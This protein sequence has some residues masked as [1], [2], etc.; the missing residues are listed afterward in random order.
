[1]RARFL[2]ALALLALMAGA[3]HADTFKLKNGTRI[4]GEATSYDDATR[5][6]YITT[7]D[8]QNQ[9]FPIDQ[10]EERSFYQIIRSKV[11]KDDARRQ[12]ELANYA[13]DAELFA[14][15]VR[16][17]DY[18]LKADSSM[19]AEIDR[20]RAVLRK[21]AGDWAMAKAKDAI[22]K[23]DKKTADKWLKK[24]VRKL[25]NEPVAREA[26]QIL[27][28]Y[29]TEITK[30]KDD[31]LEAEHAELLQK[32]LKDVKKFYDRM[33]EKNREGLTNSNGSQ[34]PKKW[35]SALDDGDRVRRDLEKFAKKNDDPKTREAIDG[36]LKLLDEHMIEIHLNLASHWTTRSSFTKALREVNKAIAID[37]ENQDAR[38]A[39]VRIEEAANRGWWN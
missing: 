21:K 15:S 31:K 33:L 24:I 34:A 2:S 1:M 16:H 32:E 13:R 23:G 28:R 12:L 26:E 3:V 14:H 39:R 8:G 18:A 6:L 19:K 9:S 22:A 25:P 5:I 4:K 35:E 38:S 17:Y 27:D 7:E 36:Y 29:H 37:P 11:A 20:E 10:F 30:A